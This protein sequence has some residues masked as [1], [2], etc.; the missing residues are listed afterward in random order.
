MFNSFAC[1]SWHEDGNIPKQLKS[2]L[3]HYQILRAVLFVKQRKCA[4]KIKILDEIML[5]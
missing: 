1:Q 5:L 4:S 2:G 3:R